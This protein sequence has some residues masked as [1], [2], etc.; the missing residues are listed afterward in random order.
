MGSQSPY[1]T[2]GKRTNSCIRYFEERL[3]GVQKKLK[4]ESP[5]FQGLKHA[6]GRFM[7]WCGSL[8][9][10]R[11][12]PLSLD[13]RLRDASR[14]RQ[15]VL[16]CLDGLEEAL[17]TVTEKNSALKDSTTTGMISSMENLALDA[18]ISSSMIQDP[19]KHANSMIDTLFRVT[20]A[21]RQP[22]SVDRYA[23][24]QRVELKDHQ[25]FSK[26]DGEYLATGG[27]SN[28]EPDL[29]E[30]ILFASLQRR[31][32]LQYTQDHRNKL[33]FGLDTIGASAGYKDDGL[34]EQ[35]ASASHID[36]SVVSYRAPSMSVS[37]IV[38]R[39]SADN[40]TESSSGSSFS[41]A[42]STASGHEQRL[43]VPPFPEEGDEGIRTCPCC[44][45]LLDF[46]SE[47][48]WK[49][50][51][52]ADLRPFV[53]TFREC[54]SDPGKLYSR[55]S[56]WFE[57]ELTFHRRRW[58]CS[59]GCSTAFLSRAALRTHLLEKHPNIQDITFVQSL[60]TGREI[61]AKA[62]ARCPFCSK[63]LKSR[64]RIREHIANH[65]K[66]IALRALY[67]MRILPEEPYEESEEDSDVV[68][69]SSV[70][71][72]QEIGSTLASAKQDEQSQ[73]LSNPDV[74]SAKRSTT[75]SESSKGKVLPRAPTGLSS[76]AA[77]VITA[78]NI[79][80]GVGAAN[81]APRKPP[82]KDESTGGTPG[83]NVPHLTRAPTFEPVS[84]LNDES[85]VM[86]P[87]PGTQDSTETTEIM[88]PEVHWSAVGSSAGAV[89]FAITR[90]ETATPW[91]KQKP[92]QG[93]A[94]KPNRNSNSPKG[95]I[96]DKPA[97]ILGNLTTTRYLV[98]SRRWIPVRTFEYLYTPERNR[99]GLCLGQVLR[100]PFDPD[101]SVLDLALPIP[102][103]EV[104]VTE[105]HDY[106]PSISGGIPLRSRR[107]AFESMLLVNDE[108]I[109]PQRIVT[110]AFHPDAEYIQEIMGLE[111]L[112]PFLQRGSLPASR[113]IYLVVGILVAYGLAMESS[114]GGHVSIGADVSNLGV[115]AGVGPYV[116]ASK[117]VHKPIFPS[118]PDQVEQPVILA[119]SLME[120]KRS[121]LGNTITGLFEKGN[122]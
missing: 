101:S 68:S 95:K 20:V 48:S 58:E 4:K 26:V 64:K 24:S 119:Y 114:S 6:Q 84:S 60:L 117:S 113:K 29:R 10:H 90:A 31:K 75:E 46:R 73:E 37:A 50:H 35:D 92:S 12:G 40:G 104:G 61:A 63:T 34:L 77:G 13:E 99:E 107:M 8:A 43:K 52:M 116:E 121:W 15:L 81:K 108:M 103:E 72:A 62:E 59:L 44:Y 19:I 97:D 69:I 98:Q 82:L 51:I 17:D 54:D 41:M 21:I 96:V 70:D 3:G 18:L 1:G 80:A 38:A 122:L 28:M 91:S 47:R 67:S 79:G 42:S 102:Q 9:A 11:Y 45:L 94:N 36:D 89:E 87:V 55:K 74:G 111:S 78:G 56:T 118:V 85:I 39:E 76:I 22:L 30:R 109:R 33:A 7:R 105:A 71:S 88:T 115:P 100:N 106:S 2:I 93:Q 53:C 23:N 27:F 25:F 66:Q 57:H 112:Q 5:E 120:I 14:I 49:K 32:F 83:E 16:D 65:Q 86:T 110:H